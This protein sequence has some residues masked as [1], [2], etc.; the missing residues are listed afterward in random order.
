MNSQA[1]KKKRPPVHTG[2]DNKV[3]RRAVQ[4]RQLPVCTPWLSFVFFIPANIQSYHKYNARY[5]Q[6][7]YICSRKK[8]K[9]QQSC[10][11]S[12]SQV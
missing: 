2:L 1:S 3:L 7:H 10:K 12:G 9:V 5:S 6:K 4:D 11:T 8:R